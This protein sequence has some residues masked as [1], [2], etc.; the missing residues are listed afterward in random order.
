MKKHITSMVLVPIVVLVFIGVAIYAIDDKFN[1]GI[2]EKVEHKFNELQN[3]NTQ[4]ATMDDGIALE[5][6]IPTK[7]VT[8]LEPNTSLTVVSNKDIKIEDSERLK[9]TYISER[10]SKK[11]YVLEVFNIGVGTASIPVTIKDNSTHSKDFVVSITR[12]SYPL[13]YGLTEIPDWEN[14]SYTVDGNNLLAKVNK[15]YKLV[16]DYAPTDLI[17]L[18]VQK[19]LYTNASGI[20]L[21]SE[22]AD[23]LDLMLKEMKKANGKIVV[24]AS[25]YRSAINQFRQYASWVSQLGQDEADKVSARPGYSEHTLGTSVDFMSQ[26]SGFTFT[27][28]FDQTE[29]GKWL[30]DNSY[31]YGFVQS[32]PEGKEN[33]TGYNYEAWHYRYIGVDNAKEYKESGLTLKEWISNK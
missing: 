19:L 17:D 32:Y 8:V 13:P 29:A 14:S 12:E 9:L 18:N 11:Y 21:R 10:D 30:K 24:I 31:L 28:N 1:L 25:G 20:M 7:E 3:K 26:D 27:N 5:V 23:Y 6:D 2:A 4:E 22:A 15:D 33:Q 16:E